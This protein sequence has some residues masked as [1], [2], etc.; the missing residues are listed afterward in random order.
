MEKNNDF[1]F[2]PEFQFFLQIKSNIFSFSIVTTDSFTLFIFTDLFFN[3]F[4]L[5][6]FKI[7]QKDE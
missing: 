4:F 1:Y 2:K 7:K 3:N 5:S 6:S